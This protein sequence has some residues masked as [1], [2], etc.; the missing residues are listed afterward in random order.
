MIVLFLQKE[1]LQQPSESVRPF[2]NL[3]GCVCV[4]VCAYLALRAVPAP[5]FWTCC[6][7]GLPNT[8]KLQSA[9]AWRQ[10]SSGFLFP[11]PGSPP[12]RWSGRLT[13][14]DGSD[15]DQAQVSMCERQSG[16]VTEATPG[17]DGTRV[18][19]GDALQDG[20]LMHVDGEVLGTGED[21]GLLVVSG[22]CNWTTKPKTYQH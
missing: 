6:R 14:R 4:F 19:C 10:R 8:H 17:H 20:G 15:Q 21:D 7:V 18:S 12:R 11:E 22:S 3:A 9:A 5:F 2:Q 16:M 1:R 13:D